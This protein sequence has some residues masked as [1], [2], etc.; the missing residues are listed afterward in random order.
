[1]GSGA[2]IAG[3]SALIVDTRGRYESEGVFEPYVYDGSDT[4]TH[5]VVAAQQWSNGRVG[6][7]GRSY[8]G[9]VQWSSPGLGIR[10]SSASPRTSSTTT[11]SGTGTGRAACSQ[12]PLLLGA[13]IAWEGA[14]G[15]IIGS[16]ARSLAL[17]NHVF[18]T[19]R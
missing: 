2:R 10:T 15:L 19:Y 6:T 17:N 9:L 5:D 14:R 4:S 3:H 13:L 16:A 7:W 12:L 8:G 1:M 11:P 18:R